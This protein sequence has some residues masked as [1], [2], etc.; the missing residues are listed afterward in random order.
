MENLY[1]VRF[2]DKFLMTGLI[3]MTFYWKKI[4]VVTNPPLSGRNPHQK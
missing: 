2:L 1:D 4:V 3:F